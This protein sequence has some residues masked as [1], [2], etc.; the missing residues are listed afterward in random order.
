MSTS[1]SN[2]NN[3]KYNDYGKQIKDSLGKGLSTGDFSG[4]NEAI[5]NSVK[6]A[7]RDAGNSII[8]DFKMPTDDSWKSANASKRANNYNYANPHGNPNSSREY[9][10]MLKAQREARIRAHQ[11]KINVNYHSTGQSQNRS[12][13]GN[14]SVQNAN[15]SSGTSLSI[16]NKNELN[17]PIKFEPVGKVSGIACIAGGITG[18]TVS[19]IVAIISAIPAVVTASVNTGLIVSAFFLAG[20]GVLTRMGFSKRKLYNRA[21]KYAL[22]AGN[23]KYASLNTLSESLGIKAKKV[24]KDIRKMLDKGFFPEGYLDEEETTLMLSTDVYKQYQQTKS[25]AIQ[26]SAAQTAAELET[27]VKNKEKVIPVSDKAKAAKA[28]LTKEQR[29]ELETMV[30]EGTDYIVKLHALNDD[31]PGE[32]I[33]KK[34]DNLENTLREIFTRVEENPEQM[35]RMHK[36]MEYYLP[37]M[38]KLVEAYKEYDQVSCPGEDILNAKNEIEKTLDTINEAFVQ[39]LNNLFRDSV[40]DVTTDAQVLQTMLK[41]EGLA[42]DI[43]VDGDKLTRVSDD[44]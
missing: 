3:S 39:L 12:S 26:A 41:Q 24:A 1:N 30:A 36:L 18:M 14:Y 23:N 42:A 2:N 31:I 32:Q 15:S 21:K 40:W 7:I 33:S 44:L 34:L 20:F 28:K 27:K 37:T 8:D 6:G 9:A 16:F 22:I 5:T 17:L 43:T 35:D 10:E 4:L 25:Y 38:L 19:S 11:Q 29:Q 13:N